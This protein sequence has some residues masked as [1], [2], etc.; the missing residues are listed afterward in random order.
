MRPQNPR[1]VLR[2]IPDRSDAAAWTFCK[3]PGDSGVSIPP[4]EP[5]SRNERFR[6]ARSA[7]VKQALEA[8]TQRLGLELKGKGRAEM[9]PTRSHPS[10]VWAVAG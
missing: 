2:R 7:C 5:E 1:Q 3:P 6:S 8:D 4:L 10:W 9:A